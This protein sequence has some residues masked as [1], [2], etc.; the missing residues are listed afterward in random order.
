MKKAWKCSLCTQICSRRE[1]LKR[2]SER[3]HNGH[4]K[5]LLR[6]ISGNSI[7]TPEESS[8]S[9]SLVVFRDEYGIK[10]TFKSPNLKSYPQNQTSYDWQDKL[11]EPIM[12]AMRFQSIINTWN[13]SRY[14]NQSANFP[15]QYAAF[16]NSVGS[17]GPVYFR[18]ET[19]SNQLDNI[20]RNYDGISGFKFDICL[21]CLTTLQTS[22]GS[23]DINL[24]EIHK[25]TP[26]TEDAIKRLGPEEYA[27]DLQR[28]LNQNHEL[29]FKECKNWANNTSGRIYLVVRKIQAT[30]KNGTEGETTL[31]SYDAFP[32]LSKVFAQ[33]KTI[34]TNSELYEFLKIAKNQ[35]KTVITLTGKPG[36]ENS[37]YMLAVSTV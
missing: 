37:K 14:Q 10:P 30:D 26:G 33:S 9:P 25:C 5:P 24:Q 3:L 1:N 2:H 7:L 36:E 12:K 34:L 31:V 13:Q 29:L 32:F 21:N 20:P 35:T 19:T 18:T 6:Y 15:Y 23:K 28:K 4:G 11:F 8:P 22:I 27:L 17:G 16:H